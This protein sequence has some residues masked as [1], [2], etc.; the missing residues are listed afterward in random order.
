[1]LKCP[2]L[3]GHSLGLRSHP[4]GWLVPETPST[5][6]SFI[7][8]DRP[9]YATAPIR[10]S[11]PCQP[12]M[13]LAG[14]TFFLPQESLSARSRQSSRF[15]G[16][17]HA[18]V[19]RSH[20]GFPDF[21]Y[22]D[23]YRPQAPH[24]LFGAQVVAVDSLASPL[25]WLEAQN[26]IVRAR[27]IPGCLNVIADHLSRPNQPIPTEWSLHPEIVRRIF[28]VWGTPEVDMFATL[29]NSHLPRVMSPIPEPRA[30][31]CL[32]TGRGGQCTCFPH[33]PCSASHA[34][35]AVHSG[36]GGDSCSPLVAVSVMVSTSTTSLC[37]TPSS[38]PLPS[39]SSVQAGTEVHLRRK[40]V[41]SARMEALMRYYKAA[42]F[43]DEVS[44]LAAAPRRPS[45]NR[46]HALRS[47]GCR[48]RV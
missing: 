32:R 19:G 1:M 3:W 27:H 11:G 48:T 42:G 26:I 5:S 18:G 41:P 23:P 34:E 12:S 40:V 31:L 38:S 37:G 13:A 25:L 8:S 21:G 6:F 45:T 9:V 28:R 36:G 29:S 7:R 4:S 10:S 17:L 14:P 44:R 30:L 15:Y 16:R 22:L 47:M 35:T 2:S 20:G 43:S 24:Q 39:G 33:S 46:M